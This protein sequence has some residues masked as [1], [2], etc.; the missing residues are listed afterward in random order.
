MELT[1]R[2]SWALVHGMTLGALFLLAFAG[3]LAGLWSLR[4]QYV[5]AAG[6]R[7]RMHRLNAGT[8]IMAIVAWVTL[9]T[10][11][12]IVYPWYRAKPPQGADLAH[13]PRYYLLSKA[14]L[15]EW[16]TFGMELK[17]HIAWFAG[18]LA[19]A[20]AFIVVRYGIRLARED[21]IRKATMVVLT[22]AFVAA[23]I[24]GLFGALITKTAPVH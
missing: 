24:A 22:L 5:T 15:A 11:T 4:P 18:P 2:E 7:E 20:A 13:Y 8:W 10:G 19:T 6:M 17:E 3:G 21:G 1:L 23:G 14:N 16:H 12:W 9:I